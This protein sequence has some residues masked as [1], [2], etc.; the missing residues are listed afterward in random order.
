MVSSWDPVR[1]FGR[2]KC[3]WPTALLAG[4]LLLIMPRLATAQGNFVR[5]RITDRVD[6]T[7]LAVLQGST[8]PLARAQFDQGAAPPN[9]PMDRMLLVLKRSPEQ[10]TALQD[11]L[12]QQQDK[13]S[14]NYHKWLSPDQFGQQF[15]P[16][17]QDIQ[18]VTSWLTSQGFQ[19]LQVSKGRTVIEFSGTAAQVESALH[20]PIHKYVVNGKDHWAN[21]SDPQIPV[22]L[23]PVVSGV[24]TLHN[25]LKKP[26]SIRSGETFVI[27]SAP[28]ERLQFRSST[29]SNALGPADFGVIYNI[30]ATMTGAGATIAVV[31][32]TNINVQ[33]V[34]DFRNKFGLVANDPQVILNGPD[35]G[36]LG[37]LEETEAV[38]DV[39]WSGAVAPNATVKLV[40]SESTN[41]AD[42][43]D[44]S[45]IYIINN[46]LADVMTESFGGCEGFVSS[47]IAS[48][49]ATLAQQAA[50]QGTTYLV[51][52]G[53]NGAAGCDD[54]TVAPATHPASVN[55]LASTPFTVAVG[56]TQFNENSS[57]STYWRTS[58]GPGLES[59]ISYIPENVWNESCTVA[60]CGSTNAGLWS[61]SGGKSIF[62]T[63]K[64]S[65]QSGVA[66][67]PPDG[68][69]D[70][71]DVSFSAAAHDPYLLCVRG[72]CTGGSPSF[73]GIS[74]TSASVQA[75]GGIMALV[76]EKT[77][78]RQGQANYVL[79]KLAARE[80][81]SSCNGSSTPGPPPGPCSFY[82][83][84]IGNNTVPGLTGFNAGVGYDLTTGLGSINVSNLVNNWSS[85]SFKGSTTTLTLNGGNAV[86]VA[87]GA[88]VPVNITVAAKSPT[89]E[90]PT[91]DVSLIANSST[92]Q[93]VEDFTLSAVGGNGSVIPTTNL[94]PGGTY[95]VTAHY[96]GDATFGASD[97]TPAISVTVN[98]E[99][100]RTS[101]GIVTFGPTGAITSSNATSIAYGSPYILNVGVTNFAGSL[102]HPN[103]IG[104]P[105]CPTGAV[106]L[107][108]TGVALDGG[109]FKLNSLGFLEDQPIQLPA[110]THSIL[111]VYGGDSSFS[112]S[113][114]STD[115]VTVSKAATTTTVSPSATVVASGASVT[116]TVT[117]VT[118]SNATANAQQEPTGTVQFF[119]GGTAFGSPVA[120]TGGVNAT[121]GFAQ[122][123]ASL[124]TTTLPNGTD[125]I[126][127][128]YSG[129]S[130]YSAS[131][132]SPAVVVTVG[133]SF[134][135]SFNPTTVII[136]SPGQSGTTTVTV[137][138]QTGYSGTINFTSSSCS[139]GLPSLT[140][141]S[142]NPSSVT[143]SGTSVLTIVTTATKTSFVIPQSRPNGFYWPMAGAAA[144][145]ASFFI[146]LVVFS[147]RRRVFRLAGALTFA[148]V[149]LACAGCT[150][151]GGPTTT[152]GTPTGTSI[153]TVTAAG[154]GFTNSTTFTL[155]VQ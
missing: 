147:Q 12:E 28:G 87:H 54:Q 42:G 84:T 110:G 14:P 127:T 77:L 39:S 30:G 82:D 76:V 31:G 64:P 104:G 107:T 106:T 48:V 124:T 122:A 9:L 49:I 47:G 57:T 85:V 71:P 128:Q 117:V 38:L 41:A 91:G 136:S 40:V 131:T 132:P 144:T 118:Q 46:N 3:I 22:A 111:A 98:P 18:V 27:T 11:L 149:M 134:S 45:E 59:A 154:G 51:S 109:S 137:A 32:R 151:P 44:L 10:E 139:A 97:S 92:G 35:P 105:A 37:D 62:F 148:C 120:V 55:V 89:T 19:S 101:L 61:S 5:P 36:N 81:L 96:A 100:S 103:A 94:L 20:A 115:V 26:Y 126:T 58:N 129:D 73:H 90:T 24:A 74:G 138:G 43:V 93:G 52:S 112:G 4:T 86:N 95:T 88:S 17:D 108:D 102:C 119:V 121:T 153:V 99:A 6:E 83:T 13:S 53:D 70:V 25:F 69:R 141:C 78:A 80:T 79:Y 23:S 60:Q 114:S 21:A 155:N 66:G 63:P 135:I 34:R 123:T 125:S 15:G 75:F 72:S 143:G 56:G 2:G 67:I 113:T 116:L 145:F 140:S 7:R 33:D 142:F 16:A 150:K 29:G 50:A 133:P 1:I 146:M 65:W 8:H 68:A 152:P 130:N